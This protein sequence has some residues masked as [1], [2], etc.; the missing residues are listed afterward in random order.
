M[1]SI[2]PQVQSAYFILLREMASSK[3]KEYARRVSRTATL[4]GSSVITDSGYTDTDRTLEIRARISE[5]QETIIKYL[6]QT[7]TLLTVV[8]NEGCYT[9]APERLSF[10][11]VGGSDD[12]NMIL[13]LM[14]SA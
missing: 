11:P 8:T 7:Y 10:P 6:L 5:A 14:I 13:T 3:I 9:C 12:P 1:I 4:D 2:S